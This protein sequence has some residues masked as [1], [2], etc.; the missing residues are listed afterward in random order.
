[1]SI[2]ILCCRNLDGFNTT[3]FGNTISDFNFPQISEELI[4]ELEKRKFVPR[5]IATEKASGEH[6]HFAAT[7]LWLLYALFG[8]LP[9]SEYSSL[10][11]SLWN[12]LQAT[13]ELGPKVQEARQIREGL[14]V[15]I[16]KDCDG[17]V[18]LEKYTYRI[19]EYI[20]EV[21][22]YNG[23]EYDR[24]RQEIPSRLEEVSEVLRHVSSFTPS[25][26]WS[27]TATQPPAEPPIV[28]KSS[29]SGHTSIAIEPAP[30]DQNLDQDE[31]LSH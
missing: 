1:M 28:L 11:N 8:N 6:G 2:A 22:D 29:V 18:N 7:Q 4:T 31:K 23:P 12:M 9:R 26:I 17:Q 27:Q 10:Q 25:E 19:V 5:L 14:A 30:I 15:R 13:T 24:V 3:Y 20:Y 16:L 21:G